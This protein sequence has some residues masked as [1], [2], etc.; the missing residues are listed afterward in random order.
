MAK[1][2]IITGGRAG[3]KSAIEDKV[4]R[5]K[6]A[7]KLFKNAIVKLPEP[8]IDNEATHYLSEIKQSRQLWVNMYGQDLEYLMILIG[9]AYYRYVVE[10]LYWADDSVDA[11]A[12]GISS[13][14]IIDPC[15]IPIHA[16]NTTLYNQLIPPPPM[17][18]AVYMIQS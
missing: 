16:V 4:F 6:N 7:K 2:T 13:A 14:A 17:A 12:Y 18:G 10:Y 8:C 15:P 11:F 3:G 5:M 9:R 1:Q